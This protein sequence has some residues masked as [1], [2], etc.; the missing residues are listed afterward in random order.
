[1]KMGKMKWLALAGMS[2]VAALL[3][4]CG[5]SNQAQLTPQ[6]KI[7][8]VFVITLENK[9]Y[10]DTFGTSTQ[11]PYLTGT[12]KPMG[13]HLTQYYGTGHV[14]LDNYVAMLSGQPASPSTETDCTTYTDFKQTG[15]TADGLA[16][17]D[18]CV[19]PAA[20]KTLPDQLKAKGL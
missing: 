4:A 17:G 16:I 1:M 7:K 13:A 5:A 15:T 20:I 3:A 6:Q 10:D 11:D 2:A 19:Y 14:S 9:N 8:H 18:G 12:L